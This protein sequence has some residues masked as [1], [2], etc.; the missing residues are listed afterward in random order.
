MTKIQ[1]KSPHVLNASIGGSPGPASM[2]NR[3]VQQG[4]IP[5]KAQAPRMAVGQFGK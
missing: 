4:G 5:G 1:V 2:T 3:I